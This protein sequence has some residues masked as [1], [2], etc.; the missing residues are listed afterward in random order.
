VNCQ[1]LELSHQYHPSRLS[2]RSPRLKPRDAK[3]GSRWCAGNG[4]G[5]EFIRAATKNLFQMSVRLS[6]WRKWRITNKVA[7]F[8]FPLRG[9]KAKKLCVLSAFAVKKLDP[10]FPREYTRCSPQGQPETA[11]KEFT[12]KNPVDSCLPN[13]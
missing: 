12:L 10:K 4:K 3:R 5:K 6:F 13:R 1:L 2:P 11:L 8:C 9:R 7:S